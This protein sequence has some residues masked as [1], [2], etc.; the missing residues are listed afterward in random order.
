MKR[1][2]PAIIILISLSILGLI[3]L[4]KSWFDNLLEV[5]ENQFASK[6][7]TAVKDVANEL[8]NNT[9]SRQLR[10]PRRNGMTFSP[11]YHLHILNAPTVSEKFSLQEVASKIKMALENRNVKDMSFEFGVANSKEELEMST[12][13]FNQQLLDTVNFK[14]V[15]FPIVPESGSELEGIADSEKLLVIVPDYR[16]PV[17]ASLKWVLIGAVAFM[18]IIIAAFYITVKSLVDQ[19]KLSE[20]KSDFINNMTHEFKTPLATISLAVDA[21]RNEKVQQDKE[22]TRYFSGIIKEENVRMNKHVETILQAGLMERQQLQLNFQP[23]HVHVLITDIL[24]NYQLQLKEKEGEIRVQLNA[25][26]D[27]IKAD[28][29]HF[30]NMISNL[31]DNA[32]KYSKEKPRITIST[33]C[34]KK[35]FVMR[36]EDNGIGM[37]KETVKRIFEKFFRAHTGNLHDVKGFGLG[38]SYVKT[39]VDTHKGKIKVESTLGKGSAF[40]IE[41]PLA[42]K[43]ES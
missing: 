3:L 18:L 40:T 5:T 16:K 39:V 8:A 32:I 1:T 6:V 11:D 19:R 27:L 17:L 9:Y 25:K 42:E 34:S 35:F 31:I 26:S 43:V 33:H 20:I 14:Q 15:W 38:M 22:K 12:S 10:L 2:F 7:E 23:L 28:E 13:R 29:V 24:D 21:L 36:V 4:Q 30:T 41:M 37:N